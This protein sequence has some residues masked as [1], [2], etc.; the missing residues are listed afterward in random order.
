MG[1]EVVKRVIAGISFGSIFFFIVL[2]VFNVQAIEVPLT[3]LWLDMLGC[4]IIGIYFGVASL[5]F[6]I[7]KW[8]RL[9]QTVI[10]VLLSLVVFFPTAIGLDWIPR[11]ASIMLTCFVVFITAYALFWFGAWWYYRRL[12]QTMNHLVRK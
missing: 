6:D 1:I 11:D 12:T 7:E 5:I 9:R 2:S 10:H 4:F 3:K 8:S